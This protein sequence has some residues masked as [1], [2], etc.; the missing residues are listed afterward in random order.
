M[1]GET[2]RR[3]ALMDERW[4]TVADISDQLQV[5]E[6]TVRRWIRAGKLVARNLGGKAGYRIRP[7]D[8]QAY[9]DSLPMGEPEEAEESK[10]A[11]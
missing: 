1:I 6:Q 10:I 4:L 2:V 11:A 5:D 9:M 3:I 8:L 7:R